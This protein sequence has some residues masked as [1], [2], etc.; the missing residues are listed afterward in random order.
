MPILQGKKAI[1]VGASSGMGRELAK[2]LSKEGY[3]LG[4]MARRMPLLK[5]LQ[6]DLSGESYIEQIDVRQP[7]VRAKIG[8]LIDQMGSIDL[9]VISISPYLDNRSSWIKKE[10]VIDVVAK[11]FI[12]VADV[13]L[14]HFTKQGHG[15]L[16]GISSTSG[17]RGNPRSPEYSAAKACV[18]TYMEGVRNKMV[19]EGI[20]VAVS[21]VVA[22]FVAVEHSPL[23]ED[24][25][26]YWEIT[27][28][29]AGR[30]ILAGIKAKKKIIYVP[31]RVQVI[32]LIHKIMPD[33][34]YQHY[35]HWL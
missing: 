25:T 2:L 7:D 32:A 1:I 26:A 17:L 24:P 35:F 29:E 5:S 31:P 28:Q 14:D 21:D 12:A 3:T 30:T 22:G 4:L 18:S 16:V 13:A 6:Q 23:G 8:T 34:L 11:G 19:L 10:R 33:F 27:V 20:D 9:M 15:H